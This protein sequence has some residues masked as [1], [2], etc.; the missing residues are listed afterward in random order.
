MFFNNK[1]RAHRAKIILG[2]A[3]LSVGELHGDMTQ[4]A[5]LEAL[6]R[7]RDQ[8][9]H[10]LMCTDLAARGLDIPHVEVVLNFEMPREIA[11]YVHR[12]GRTA[13]AGARNL[14]HPRGRQEPEPHE[15]GG[16][17][18]KRW[19]RRG[20]KQINPENAIAQARDKIEN[21]ESEIAEIRDQEKEEKAIELPRWRRTERGT[22]WNLKKI[23]REGLGAPGSNL[24]RKNRS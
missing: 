9:V 7:F 5:R 6:Q 23:S 22:L 10:F 18:S 1:W 13:R 12:V 8:E 4:R 2:L 3:G 20:E 19:W 11:S 24:R 17:T 15:K 14:C 21:M 16:E